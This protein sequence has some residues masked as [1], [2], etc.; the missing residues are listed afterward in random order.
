MDGIAWSFEGMVT[1]V[2]LWNV[3][4]NSAF[5]ALSSLRYMRKAWCKKSSDSD[6][7]W[8]NRNFIWVKHKVNHMEEG[9]A[10]ILQLWN[11]VGRVCKCMLQSSTYNLLNT[12]FQ[13]FT[14]I[15]TF[16]WGGT[17]MQRGRNYDLWLICLNRKLEIYV[18]ILVWKYTKCLRNY[19]LE[20]L[21]TLIRIWQIWSAIDELCNFACIIIFMHHDWRKNVQLEGWPT[22]IHDT[23]PQLVLGM[24]Y[25]VI[26]IESHY[27]V[28]LL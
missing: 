10:N 21:F 17:T 5:L 1:S 27:F 28:Y 6:W 4:Q 18:W 7:H 9:Y 24:T 3:S 26:F 23:L 22:Y 16:F 11:V 25:V 13:I 12:L 20:M 15:V 2:Q 8:K 19:H 14:A